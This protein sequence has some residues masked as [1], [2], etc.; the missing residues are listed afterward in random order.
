MKT[1]SKT[2]DCVK[3]KDQIQAEMIAEY[4]ARKDDFDSYDA[5]L[6]AKADGSP[7]IKKMRKKFGPPSK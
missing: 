7:W 3:M 5:F 4:E 1:K 6:R 2:F